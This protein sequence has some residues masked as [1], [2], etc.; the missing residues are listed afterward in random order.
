MNPWCGLFLDMGL[1]KT[2]ISLMVLEHLK[3]FGGFEPTI[4]LAPKHVANSTWPDEIEEWEFDFHFEVMTGNARKR[5]KTLQTMPEMLITNYEQI[6]W[7][8]ARP[9]SKRYRILILDEISKMKSTKSNRWRSLAKKK[10]LSR[11][12]RRIGLTGMPVPN[13]LIDLFGIMKIIDGGESFP[14]KGIFISKYFRNVSKND[15]YPI[16][17]IN[18]G[19]EKK[20]H[21]RIAPRVLAFKAEDYTDLPPYRF[22]TIKLQLPDEAKDLYETLQHDFFLKIGDE[23]IDVETAAVL[24][25]KLRQL[26]SGFLYNEDSTVQINKERLGACKDF[27]DDLEGEPV[28]IG[29]QYQES[30]ARLKKAFPKAPIIGKGSKPAYVRRIIKEWNAGKHP[31]LLIH[32]KSGGHGLNLQHGGHHILWYEI[33]WSLDDYYQLLA[34]LRRHGQKSRFISVSHLLFENTIDM[35]MLKSLTDKK[36]TQD[37]LYK[38][39]KKYMKRRMKHAA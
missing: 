31:V 28:I 16:Y 33:T 1:G 34:R 25:M 38:A 2:V 27:V 32:P 4:V 13:H 23:I 22:K 19:A 14:L 26:L 21:K 24:S 5:A 7:L 20:I 3:I 39:I 6:P 37:R 10:T 17:R 36:G 8:M 11:F 18:P 9:E 15:N 12:D 35:T 30:L 29:Y